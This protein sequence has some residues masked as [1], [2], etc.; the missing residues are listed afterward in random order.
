M[1]NSSYKRGVCSV[2]GCESPVLAKAL[3]SAHYQRVLKYG[4]PSVM[5][6]VRRYPADA[7][8]DEPGCDQR[9]S[10]KNVCGV[11]YRRRNAE[12]LRAYTADYRTWPGVSEQMRQYRVNTNKQRTEYQQ[13]WRTKNPEH[14]RRLIAE[15]NQIRRCRLAGVEVSR[16]NRDSIFVRD[17]GLCAYCGLG[18]DPWN[19][20][21]DHVLA[22]AKGGGHTEDNVVAS[23]PRC[24]MKKGA[25]PAENYRREAVA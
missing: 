1:S 2:D 12:R 21:L 3:C 9:P 24:N 23:C 6:N 15:S 4:D 7:V 14:N 8:C 20:H 19:W 11:H 18:L 22:I 25:R 10:C 17:R 5:I 13:A 16:F